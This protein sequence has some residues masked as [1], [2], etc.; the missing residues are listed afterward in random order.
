MQEMINQ[1]TQLEQILDD[2]QKKVQKTYDSIGSEWNDQQYVNMGSEIDEIVQ[3]LSSCY[4][5]LS[6]SITKLQ[7]RK[8]M[9]EDY[10]NYR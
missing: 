4:T 5:E 7:L 3:S 2:M 8:S 1:L 6:S 10:L 9:L